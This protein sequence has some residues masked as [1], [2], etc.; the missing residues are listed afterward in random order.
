M[1]VAVGSGNPVKRE[2]VELAIESDED[3]FGDGAVVDPLPVE[4][5][6]SEQPTGHAETRIGAVNRAKRALGAGEYDLGVGI[7]GGVA[8]F[9]DGSGDA[10]RPGPFLIM[11]AAATDGDRVE[12]AAGPS[13]PLPARIGDRIEA[14]EEL[15]PVLDDVLGTDGIAKRQGAAGVFTGGRIDRAGALADAVAGAIGPFV[16]SLYE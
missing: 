15:G 14:G 7:E 9:P 10:R 6:V 5:G 12:T 4:S 13:I 16:C 8:T 2:A 3:T 1:R 11:W